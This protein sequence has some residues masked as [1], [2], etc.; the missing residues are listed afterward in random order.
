MEALGER[1]Q[2]LDTLRSLKERGRPGDQQI[3][4]GESPGIDL[5]DELPERVEALITNVAS[6]ALD[7]FQ[8]HPRR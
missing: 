4:T 8:P 6:H 3:E 5:I 2:P 7:R 1:L